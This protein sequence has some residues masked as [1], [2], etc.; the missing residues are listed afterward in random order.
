MRIRLILFIFSTLLFSYSSFGQNQEYTILWGKDEIGS[1][2]VSKT[3][4]GS[5]VEY[6]FEAD[7]EFRVILKYKRHTEVKAIFKNDTLEYCSSKS[8]MNG[9]LKDFKSSHRINNSYQVIE[10]PSDSSFYNGFIR[11]TVARMYFEE[12]TKTLKET[13]AEGYSK[14]C[15]IEALGSG[16][17][18]LYLSD[19]KTN[20]YKYVNGKLQEV[21]VNR[22]WFDLIFKRVE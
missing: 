1:M 2:T 5:K 20:I 13:Y 16:N 11:H 22:T 10:H 8:L 19:D 15:P 9:D 21:Q 6:G 3:V 14:F 18:K 4:V 12:P 7:V 17:Y